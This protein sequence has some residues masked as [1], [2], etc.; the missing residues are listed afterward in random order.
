MKKRLTLALAL[1]A[2]IPGTLLPAEADSGLP[3]GIGRWSDPVVVSVDQAH[4]ETSIVINPKNENEMLICTPSGVPNVFDNQSYFHMSHNGGESWKPVRVE[5]GP[6]DLR[7]YA[8][9]GGDCDV[10]YDQGGTMYAADTWLGNLSVGRSEDGGKTWTGTPLT[11]AAPIVDRPW[12]VGTKPGTLHLSYH[13]LQ[14]CMPSAIWYT[15]STDS[16]QTFSP[17]VS[18]A[19][20]GPDGAFTWEG[21]LVVSRDEKHLYLVYTR[22]QDAQGREG[23]ESVWV[24]S[25]HDAGASWSST[26]L[27]DRP[28]SASF[29]YPSLAMD[30]AGYLHAVY[31]SPTDKDVPVWYQMSKDGAE[32]W[33]NPLPLTRGESGYSPWIDASGKGDAAVAWYGSSDPEAPG[34][35]DSDWY[36]YW[37]RIRDSHLKSGSISTGR[38]T[39]EPIFTGNS[40]IPE[41]EM[42]RLDKKGRMHIG[43]S[44]FH[45]TE[46]GQQGWAIFYQRERR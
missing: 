17:V 27:A 12:L 33:T 1:L 46:S 9:E 23:P 34:N 45:K 18:I 44:A 22:R 3:D 20:A 5:G 13:A 2:L 24:A 42:V 36:F 21:N 38:T 14:C 32:T 28:T 16:G 39:K 30:D 26:K 4:R 41:F 25:S 35:T 6:D 40:T 8:F 11:V 7:N 43:M 37:A 31:S 29:L 19:T 10:A 15:K